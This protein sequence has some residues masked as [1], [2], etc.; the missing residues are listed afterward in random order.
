MAA[1]VGM[2]RGRRSTRGGGLSPAP[3]TL[4][5]PASPA[6]LATL[7]AQVALV[8]AAA[9]L[10]SLPAAAQ[11]LPD[12]PALS[13]SSPSAAK[14]Q[15]LRDQEI[16]SCRPGESTT[17]GDGRDRSAV[18]RPLRFVYRHDAAPPWFDAAQVLALAQRSVQAWSPCGVT[19]SVQALPP[20]QSPAEG[21]IQ[22]VWTDT[23]SRGQFGLANVPARTLSL[24]PG[25]FRLLRE[26]NPAYPAEQTLQ[27]VLSHEMG[28]FYGLMAHSRRCVDVMSYYDNGKGQR[29]TLRDASAWGSVVEY[30][31]MLPTACD[32]ARCRALNGSGN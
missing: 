12:R 26:R 21:D 13:A 20:R 11:R 23:G 10:M 3:A 19:A 15:T 7:A 31:S 1:A 17:W 2:S 24:G 6:A 27:M 32:L 25:L 9:A 18:S 4:V 29:C 14:A 8:A 16:A 5:A 30:R 22:I 28:H